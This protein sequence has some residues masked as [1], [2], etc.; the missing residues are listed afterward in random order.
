MFPRYFRGNFLHSRYT[1]PPRCAKHRDDAAGGAVKDF[2]AEA[3]RKN[4]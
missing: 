3:R 4:E 1:C 2:T